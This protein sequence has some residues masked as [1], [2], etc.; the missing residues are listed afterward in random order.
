[1]SPINHPAIG[2][3][4]FIMDTL[5][6]TSPNSLGAMCRKGKTLSSEDQGSG[7]RLAKYNMGAQIRCVCCFKS[8]KAFKSH[9]NIHQA[10]SF[11]DSMWH[12]LEICV[13]DG[14]SSIPKFIGWLFLFGHLPSLM[15]NP[16]C[17]NYKPHLLV[18]LLGHH[19]SLGP[20]VATNL[21][22][23]GVNRDASWV[24]A[25]ELCWTM[26]FLMEKSV[27]MWVR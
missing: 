25:Y 7:F 3:S 27:W 4:P 15:N 23:L 24:L 12:H 13:E 2:V 17:M 11:Y 14:I 16:S 5:I 21:Q 9:I 10:K 20:Y 18:R 19:R 8:S 6:W 1:M 22:S 26:F